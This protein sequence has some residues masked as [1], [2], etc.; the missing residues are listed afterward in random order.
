LLKDSL[1]LP[2]LIRIVAVLNGVASL[3][4][5]NLSLRFADSLTTILI[6]N[7]Q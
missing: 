7:A 5:Q 3:S 6:K 4:G 1:S 2:A